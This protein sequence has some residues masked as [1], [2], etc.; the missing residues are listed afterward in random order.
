[1]IQNRFKTISRY[2]LAAFALTLI[3]A[4]TDVPAASDS[5][6]PVTLIIN[7]E[8]SDEGLSE[9]SDIMAGVADAMASEP[10]FVSAIVYQ[11][12]E[13][14]TAFVLQEV[15]ASKEK[16]GEH[17]DRIVASGDWAHINSLLKTEPI[18]GYYSTDPV[19][20]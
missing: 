13:R 20:P 6:P 2:V 17:F 14:P 1:M 3:A 11:N 16:H 12:V 15:W 8:A 9:F 7:F 5:G 10:G 4:C 18:M 19:D